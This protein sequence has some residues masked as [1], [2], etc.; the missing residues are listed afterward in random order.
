[1]SDTTTRGI[2]I[3]VES[4]YMEERSEPRSNY[5]FFAY[6]ITMS[7]VGNETAQLVSREWI[8]TDGDGNVER[9]QGPGVV[10]EFPKLAPGDT[11]EYTSFCPLTTSFG[12]MQGHYVMK[13]S[14]GETFEAEIAPFTLAV[15]GVV[16]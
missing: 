12:S 1:M 11:F 3:Q 16:N 14:T 7:N 10:G 13:T 15:P 4:E 8:I 2:R 9:V 5:F 6:H